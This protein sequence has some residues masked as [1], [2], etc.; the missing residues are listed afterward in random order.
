MR[1]RIWVFYAALNYVAAVII[2]VASS[3]S[4]QTQIYY[5][6]SCL[7]YAHFRNSCLSE[8]YRQNGKF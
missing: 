6:F 5:N 2:S 8:I 3:Y 1:H 4:Y 7:L